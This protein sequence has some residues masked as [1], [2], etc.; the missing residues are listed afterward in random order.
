VNE[1]GKALPGVTN[2]STGEVAL[3]LAGAIE[4]AIATTAVAIGTI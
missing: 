3:A 2:S 4:S 1:T